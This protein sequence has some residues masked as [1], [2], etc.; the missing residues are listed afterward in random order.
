M[1][2][3]SHVPALAP[4]DN[5]PPAVQPQAAAP[6]PA[7]PAPKPA[8]PG[9]F[10]RLDANPPSQDKLG[11][12][13]GPLMAGTL[14]ILLTF[15]G[16]GIWGAF[17][18]LDSAA[19]APGVVVVES[20]RRLVQHLE[21]GIVA[22]LLV[23]E[24]QQ[25]KDGQVLLRL[26]STRS[27]AQWQIL[28]SDLDSFL[29]SEARLEAERDNMTTLAFPQ[30]LT[31][32]AGNALVDEVMHSQRNLFDT[33]RLSLANQHD[34]LT[35]RV[36]QLYQQIDGL[37]ALEKSKNDQEKLI[38]DEL[39]GKR[40]LLTKGLVAKTQVLALEREKA[41]LEGERGDHIASIARTEQAI[42]ENKMQMSQL[43]KQ[44][45]EEVAKELRE[46]QGQIS[47]AREKLVA[48]ADVM[49]RVDVVAPVAGQVLNLAVHTVGGV[50]GPGQTIAEIVPND[51]KLIAEVQI[52]TADIDTVHEGMDV[53]LR[54]GV[55]DARLSPTI[56]GKLVSISADRVTDPQT[57]AT[58]YKG[59][60]EI[61]EAEAKKL[62]PL[63][64]QAGM[65]VE[66]M[67]KR[68]ERTALSYIFKPLMDRLHG[69]FHE[70]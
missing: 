61:P 51:D 48:A 29:A 63:R 12:A 45:Q 31:D 27:K 8:R 43:D 18:P 24:G 32:R 21:G 50:V 46:T 62:E 26:D 44:R 64:L 49:S 42:G 56:D 20:N 59:R 37:R 7:A 6:V 10:A 54:F 57:R 34:I 52:N 22:E 4:E 47:E 55:V 16:I 25:V 68:G 30:E 38:D 70:N 41:R 33:R 65:N 14:V 69:A 19:I 58:Y 17:A 53:S 66:S 28:R 2:A 11:D 9:L 40:M 3:M 60:V 67:I 23:G 36:Q 13:R 35:Q 5:P 39:V 1:P 15:L